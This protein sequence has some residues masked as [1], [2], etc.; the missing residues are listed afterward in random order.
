[1]NVG[2]LLFDDVQLTDFTGPYDVF[3]FAR[4]AKGEPAFRVFTLAASPEVRCNG[5]IIVRPD[6]SLDDHPP[7][8][9]L[10]VPGGRGVRSE[11]NNPALIDWIRDTADTS[12]LAA[13][14]CTGAR[15]MAKTGLWDGLQATTHWNSIEFLRSTFP[16]VDVLEEVR[17]VDAGKYLSSAGV[18]AGIDLAL[19][20]V[21]RLHGA[22]EAARVA[23]GL[24]YEARA[25]LAI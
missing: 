7:I 23:R 17:Y 9:L 22:E 10:L 1:V 16:A 4:N 13:T 14:V 25:G 12:T 8:E 20:I 15:L 18:T 6:F 11:E 21:E 2:I 24:E 3:I 19:Y 5:G